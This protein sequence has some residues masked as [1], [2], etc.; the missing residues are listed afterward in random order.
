[1]HPRIRRLLERVARGKT[2]WR[3]LPVPF[4]KARVLVTPDAALSYLR[5]GDDW[6][7]R[8]L[9]DTV[10]RQ[11]RTG[12]VVWDVGANVGVFGA[13]AAVK[14]GAAGSVLCVEP[15]TMLAQ[16]IRATSSRLPDGC[17]KL[18]VLAAAVADQSGVAEFHIAERGRASNALAAHSGQSQ[19]GG[20]RE[21]QL[22]PVVTLDHLLD[23]SRPPD[24]VKIDVEGA[25]SV[26]LAGASRLLEAVR[27]SIYI[28]VRTHNAATVTGYF[29]RA[30][31]V[32]FDPAK[33]IAGQAPLP[34]CQWN[35]L[36]IAAEKVSS[37]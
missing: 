6:C 11:V 15:D 10:A 27:P 16:L 7:D 24:F 2:I 20:V 4:S 37:G 5:T 34:A 23:V 14:S 28:E 9:L 31:Y 19:A 12:D 36:A 29:E 21:R 33:P 30:S 25:E 18:E 35:T 13:A 1:M 17:A 32:L 26:I 22:V 3:R 8:E